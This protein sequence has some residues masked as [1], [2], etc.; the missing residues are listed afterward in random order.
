MD[1][2][3]QDDNLK[4]LVIVGEWTPV[5]DIYKNNKKQL[6]YKQ[7]YFLSCQKSLLGGGIE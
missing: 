7:G 3:E 1:R 4:A 6:K 5:N 2:C